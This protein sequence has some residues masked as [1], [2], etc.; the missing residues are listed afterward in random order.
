MTVTYTTRG[1]LRMPARRADEAPGTYGWEQSF[2]YRL[3]QERRAGQAAETANRGLRSLGFAPTAT[4]AAAIL[5]DAATPAQRKY[6]ADL[7][8]RSGDEMFAS[9]DLDTISR[10][11]ASRLIG[12]LRALPAGAAPAARSAASTARPLPQVPAGRYAVEADG[13]LGFYRVTADAAGRVRGLYAQAS[14]ALWPITKYDHR[15]RVLSAIE[16]AGPRE[17]AERYGREIGKCGCCGRTLTDEASR[18]AGL[19]PDCQDHFGMMG[20]ER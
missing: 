18:E 13:A 3:Q 6:L 4:P 11:D 20:A 12:Q 2:S 14:D 9:L 5:T 10:A 1:L 15:M 7:I 16:A 17:C 19:G 8:A